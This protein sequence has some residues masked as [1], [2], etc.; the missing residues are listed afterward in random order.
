MEKVSLNSNAVAPVLEG[1]ENENKKGADQNVSAGK[2]VDGPM[3]DDLD[4]PE[5]N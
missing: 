4:G 1:S 5:T 2:P 3:I